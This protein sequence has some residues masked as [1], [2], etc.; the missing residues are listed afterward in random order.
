MLGNPPPFF[1]W[2]SWCRVC[3]TLFMKI[4]LNFTHQWVGDT[5]KPTTFFHL[6]ILMPSLFT[7]FHEPR[8]KFVQLVDTAFATEWIPNWPIRRILEFRSLSKV[9]STTCT[10]FY[11]GSWHV[12]IRAS[13]TYQ[14]WMTWM[15]LKPVQSLLV[16]TASQSPLQNIIQFLA[17]F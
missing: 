15:T 2:R 13:K 17:C 12:G 14:S 6:T 3:S 7:T 8:Y 5:W 16:D 11:W 4:M 10:D 9:D 1:T